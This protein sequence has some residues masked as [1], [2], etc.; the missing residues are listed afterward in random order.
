MLEKDR[1]EFFHAIIIII[2]IIRVVEAPQ[3]IWQPDSSIFPVPSGELQALMLSSHFFSACLFSTPFHGAFPRGFARPDQW[4][5][6]PYHCRLPLF[7]MVKEVFM[8]SD[9]L[10][11]FRRDILVGNTVFVGNA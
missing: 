6:W 8:W 9:C 5:K 11:N 7:A 4:E 1:F 2:I 10:L 3:M